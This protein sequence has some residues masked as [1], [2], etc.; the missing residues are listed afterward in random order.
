MR[1][2][3]D[4][5]RLDVD[6]ERTVLQAA[7]DNGIDIP[8]L[9]DHAALKPFAGC[10]L[11]LVEVLGRKGLLPSCAIPVE[12]GMEVRTDTPRLRALR[13]RILELIL[14]EHPY[15]C[16]VC[17]EKDRCDDMKSTIRKV[18][19]T[20]GCVLCA[21]NG[22]C[23]LQRV[24]ASLGLDGVP[25]TAL[26]RNQDVRKDDPFFD[27][28]LNLC[29]LCG[30]CVR[31]CD[32]VRGASVLAFLDRGP[33]SVVGT[34]FGRTLLE[35]G[36]QFCGACVDVC[37]TGS[38]FDRG[39]RPNGLPDREVLTICPLCGVGCEL[40]VELKEGRVLRT[41]PSGAG[42]ANKGQA[43]VKGRFA[44]RDLAASPKRLTHPLIR[45]DG[46]LVP[47]GWEE[48]LDFVAR[49][50]S[51]FGKNEVAFRGSNQATIEDGFLFA[52][53]AGRF[54]G[55]A[56]QGES[57]RKGA[58][59]GGVFRFDRNEIADAGTVVLYGLDLP[60]SHPLIWL[61]VVK[62]VRRGAALVVIDTGALPP[63]RQ[64]TF[65]IRLK[66]GQEAEFLGVLAGLD[67]GETAS[68]LPIGSD[69]NAL[70]GLLKGRQPAVLLFDAR[71]ASRLSGPARA[72][73]VR[74][75]PLVGEI[76]A[77]GMNLLRFRSPAAF[78]PGTAKALFTLGSAPDP[79]DRPFEFI[80]LVQCYF[81]GG[82]LGA[83]A[84]LPAA[85][86]LETAGTYI[87]VEGR[88][89]AFEKILD[90]PGEAKSDGW[91][92]LQL[93]RK[94]GFED[95]PPPEM[96]KDLDDIRKGKIPGDSDGGRPRPDGRPGPGILCGA[97][98]DT[99]RGLDLEREIRGLK[100]LR[101]KRRA[102]AGRG[103]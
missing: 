23:E 90:P 55:P 100:A 31:I 37:P 32:E 91:I 57:S 102:Q 75:V 43:C 40:R 98:L 22:R 42:L 92:I 95:F 27:R 30:R 54:S 61:E 63:I 77:N 73:G 20:T 36:C 96:E 68:D 64:E 70:S 48:A 76:N 39:P 62:A 24:C 13:L 33:A 94:M 85:T 19:E 5:R 65:R 66:P 17:A 50:L 34:A 101:E 29:I 72:G 52:E 8:S 41:A 99:Y 15:A 44:I 11:C 79:H 69:L 35:A 38:L 16:L 82:A 88:I 12:E 59:V 1:I 6:G 21:R 49:G 58:A 78:E 80:V 4:G 14:S 89:L 56:G 45:K 103:R 9:C 51:R 3:I 71:L 74:L 28:D 83:G 81:D 97:G 46:R 10:R 7:R 26:Y 67:R 47:A 86:F 18:G 87:N 60:I 84:V 93:A 2:T 25:L 53:F